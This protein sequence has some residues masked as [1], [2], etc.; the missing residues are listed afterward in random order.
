MF[1]ARAPVL[2]VKLR[3]CFLRVV[4]LLQQVYVVYLLFTGCW[5]FF[6]PWECFIGEQKRR[7]AHSHRLI[8]FSL[9]EAHYSE[10]GYDNSSQLAE[11]A[12]G[13]GEITRWSE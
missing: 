11:L 13:K 9:R 5:F 8:S 1:P 4:Y 3:S 2:K 12:K 10:V 7:K 6:T